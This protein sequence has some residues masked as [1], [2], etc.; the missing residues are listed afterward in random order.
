MFNKEK[1]FH[2]QLKKY[3]HVQIRKMHSLSKTVRVYQ[4]LLKELILCTFLHFLYH[5]AAAYVY[6]S[7]FMFLIMLS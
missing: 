1:Y 6:A 3:F 7:Q 4:G 5:V 2:V